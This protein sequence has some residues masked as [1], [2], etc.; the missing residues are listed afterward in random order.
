MVV[1]DNITLFQQR[2]SYICCTQLNTNKL[3]TVGRQIHT[4]S[5]LVND[6]PKVFIINVTNPNIHMK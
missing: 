2:F 3:C 4:T 6:Q 1:G 5:K